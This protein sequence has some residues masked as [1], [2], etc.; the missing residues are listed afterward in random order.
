MVKATDCVVCRAFQW[1]GK[2]WAEFNIVDHVLMDLN[3]AISS[4]PRHEQVSP[5]SCMDCWTPFGHT[6]AA[7]YRDH[8]RQLQGI[9]GKEE[10]LH[11][12]RC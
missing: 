3:L 6:G 4:L 12:C 8:E 7:I 9:M 2:S 10:A 1:V 5:C 11:A